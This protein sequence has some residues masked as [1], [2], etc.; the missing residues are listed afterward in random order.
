MLQSVIATVSRLGIES[1]RLEDDADLSVSQC[2]PWRL[3]DLGS[4]RLARSPRRSAGFARSR[5]R[6]RLLPAQR[7]RRFHGIAVHLA[8]PFHCHFLGIVIARILQLFASHSWEDVAAVFSVGAESSA[9]NRWRATV[10][11]VVLASTL[12]TASYRLRDVHFVGELT[13]RDTRTSCQLSAT[14]PHV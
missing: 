5:A 2:L 14:L 8:R 11:V 3:L 6:N 7:A 4:C 10:F 13:H 12:S 9:E 1:L